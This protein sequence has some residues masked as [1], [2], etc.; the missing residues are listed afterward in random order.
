MPSKAASLLARRQ[1]AADR[2]PPLV[3]VLRGTLRQRYVRC[4][5][6]GC[7]CRTGHGHGPVFYLS[8]TLAGGRTTQITVAAEDVATARRLLRNYER[9]RRSLE[10]ISE[11]NRE[12]LRQRVL[13]HKKSRGG[14]RRRRR[15]DEDLG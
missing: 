3:D 2:V 14:R 8:V 4:G 6:S 9:V 7:H 11:M 5:N 1:A 10:A 15:S 12:L 13:P